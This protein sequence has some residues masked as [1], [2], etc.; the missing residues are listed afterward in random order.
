MDVVLN[1]KISI[2]LEKINKGFVFN[3]DKFVF[4]NQGFIGF[5]GEFGKL[6]SM[7]LLNK[8]CIYV[9]MLFVY[10]NVNFIYIV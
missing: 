10:K 9:Y 7:G 1:Y 5:F 8:V 3:N 4:V 2:S 6:V